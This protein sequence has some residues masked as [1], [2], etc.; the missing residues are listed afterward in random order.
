M[1]PAVKIS[2]WRNCKDRVEDF[3]L[4]TALSWVMVPYTLRKNKEFERIFALITSTQFLGLPLL[5]PGYA[6]KL[7][8][9]LTPNLLNWRRMTSFHRVLEG[10]DLKHIGH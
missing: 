10:A 4:G 3:L 2:W 8:P 5:P 6:L 1:K 7:L 9:Y